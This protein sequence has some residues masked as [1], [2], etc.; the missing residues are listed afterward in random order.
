MCGDGDGSGD[1]AHTLVA[2]FMSEC[3]SN[4]HVASRFIRVKSWL[5]VYVLSVSFERG[6]VLIHYNSVAALKH[7]RHHYSKTCPLFIREKCLQKKTSLKDRTKRKEIK[8]DKMHAPHAQHYWISW[9]STP[10][11]GS[12]EEKKAHA[13]CTVAAT[14]PTG[15]TSGGPVACTLS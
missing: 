7:P 2:F 4:F 5:I 11:P 12:P 8:L 9:V 6:F 15:A 14:L 3:P 13:Y 1:V 10:V